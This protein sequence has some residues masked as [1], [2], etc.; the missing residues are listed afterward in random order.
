MSR[1]YDKR[2]RLGRGLDALKDMEYEKRE[3]ILRHIIHLLKQRTPDSL[4]SDLAL[5]FRFDTR[6]LRWYEHDPY[7]WFVFNILEVANAETLEVVEDYLNDESGH[8]A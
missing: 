1:W 6:R 2:P 4:I 5:D 8:A 7:C 3:P